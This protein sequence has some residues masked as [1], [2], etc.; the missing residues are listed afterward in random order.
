MAQPEVG[1]VAELG[2][3][4]EVAESADPSVVE[5]SV[6][7]SSPPRPRPRPL[8]LPLPWPDAPSAES[9]ELAPLAEDGPLPEVAPSALLAPLP[10][11]ELSAPE[12]P[13]PPEPPEPP[14]DPPEPPPP[15]PLPD[16]ALASL[17]FSSTGAA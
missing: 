6:D 2:P 8:P 16:E 15:E 7:E 12:A 14:P 13:D 17:S 11:P 3:L 1:P 9:C 5:P 10:E 4:G